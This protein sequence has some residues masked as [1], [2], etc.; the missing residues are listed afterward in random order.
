V[1]VQVGDVVTVEI[2]KVEIDR[3]RIALAWPA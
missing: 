1:A 3:G 2:Q